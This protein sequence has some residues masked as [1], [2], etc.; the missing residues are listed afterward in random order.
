[1][2]P[3]ASM[4][5]PDV[6]RRFYAAFSAGDLDTVLD[7]VDPAIAFEPL[8]GVLYDRHVFHGHDG[9]VEWF[10]ALEREWDGFE[11]HVDNAVEVGDHVV[12]FVHLVAHRGAER[13]QAEVA[14]ECRF[15]GERISSLVGRDAWEVAAELGIAR[16]E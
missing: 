15:S 3:P 4:S 9:I 7:A 13:L 12:A 14:V 16:G 6:V 5:R 10:K 1:M 11:T 8:L 2:S